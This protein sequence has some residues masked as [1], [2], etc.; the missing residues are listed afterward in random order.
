MS[1]AFPLERRVACNLPDIP[2]VEGD[3]IS[4]CELCEITPLPKFNPLGFPIPAPPSADFGCYPFSVYVDFDPD[5]QVDEPEFKVSVAYLT[6]SV[7]GYCK[8][9]LRFKVRMA[10]GGGCGTIEVAAVAIENITLSGNQ[11]IDGVAVS[12][13]DRVLTT[14]QTDTKDNDVWNVFAGAWERYATAQ[15]CNLV[16]A[17]FGDINARTLWQMNNA[18]E[19]EHGT[20]EMTFS[21]MSSGMIACRL[22]LTDPDTTLSG[23]QSVDGSDT[24]EGD[25]IAVDT[26]LYAPNT[27]DGIWSAMD[28]G[29]WV[30][31]YTTDPTLA[32][33]V[34][35][36]AAGSI[37]TV[38]D[39]YS[40][41]WLYVVGLNYYDEGP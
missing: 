41:P 5:E 40:S 29:A 31:L 38:Y 2:A 22:R 3:L 25:L 7:T 14:M 16:L 11:T 35:V 8:P 9:Q 17:R 21:K 30:Q 19:P 33:G 23:V 18:S 37:V 36:L 12:E 32:P 20:D 15:M 13:G 34:P 4:T 1:S 6:S 10:A 24:V 39:G 26:G 28:D 27:I